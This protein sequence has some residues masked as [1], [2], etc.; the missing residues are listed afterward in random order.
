MYKAFGKR[1][2]DV[3]IALAG[4]ITCFPVFIILAAL[5]AI[6]LRSNPFFC[7]QR[8]GFRQKVFTLIKLK[9]M[10]DVIDHN[11]C[12]LP[13][14]ERI[15][16]LGGLIR[17]TSLDELPQLWNVLVGEMSLIGPR[18]LLMEYLPLY[19]TDQQKRHDVRPGITGWAQVHGRNTISWE[20]KFNLDLWYVQNLSFT[21]DL[22]ILLLTVSQLVNRK[23]VSKNDKIGIE[24]FKG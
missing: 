6:W 3:V 1:A 15:F 14:S 13:D 10:R 19:N 21:L 20:S 12:L 9:T 5:L 22:K 4:I 18:P 2:F 11:G 17:K 24:K 16:P 8:P 7:Q 23:H